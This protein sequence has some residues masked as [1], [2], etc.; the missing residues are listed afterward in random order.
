MATPNL[1]FHFR[2]RSGNETRSL[3]DLLIVL[4]T[5]SEDAAWHLQEGH[6]QHALSTQGYGVLAEGISG[7]SDQ[8][9]LRERLKTAIDMYARFQ[10]E[11]PQGAGNIADSFS[12]LA[13]QIKKKA[14][15]VLAAGKIRAG[16]AFVSACEAVAE[17]AARAAE[18]AKSAVQE[19]AGEAPKK[20]PA[21]KP[22]ARK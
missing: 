12:I 5:Q 13:D 7:P 9:V 4:Q 16:A 18:K 10:R 22:A 8:A 21:K 14:G 1:P 20:G 6:L 15:E 3:A 2:W 11:Q 19:K 17:K